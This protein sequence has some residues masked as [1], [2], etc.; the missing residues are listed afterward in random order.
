MKLDIN[1]RALVQ[2]TVHDKKNIEIDVDRKETH[3]AATEAPGEWVEC[4]PSLLSKQDMSYAIAY[5]GPDL[6]GQIERWIVL[7]YATG[8]KIFYKAN[9]PDLV[10]MRI[11]WPEAVAAAD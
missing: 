8:G 2:Q 1:N 5:T 9:G 6:K 4:A 11:E 3:Y 7:V 10:S